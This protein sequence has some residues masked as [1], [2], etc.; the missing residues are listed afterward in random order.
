[1]TLLPVIAWILLPKM[2]ALVTTAHVQVVPTLERATTWNRR[3]SMTVLVTMHLVKV[4]QTPKVATMP[5]GPSP[6][7]EVASTYWTCTTSPIWIAAE[8]V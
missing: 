2:T 5:Q 4:A 7:M 6:M 8:N 1:M 3:P